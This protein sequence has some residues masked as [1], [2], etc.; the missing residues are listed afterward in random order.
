[1]IAVNGDRKIEKPA[2]NH[3]LSRDTGSKDG[4]LPIVAKDSRWGKV[5]MPT[6]PDTGY[7]VPRI[8]VS[9]VDEFAGVVVVPASV[10][11]QSTR[12]LACTKSE[13]P[14]KMNR[15]KSRLRVL[16]ADDS[17]AVLERVSGLLREEFDVVGTVSDGLQVP[18]AIEKTKPDLLVIDIGLPGMNGIQTVQRLTKMG[19]TAKIV[20]LTVSQDEDYISAAIA[21]GAAGYVTKAR[22][23][24]DLILALREALA[25]KFFVWRPSR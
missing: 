5:D 22:M 1:V 20:F 8:L 3:A 13:H 15:E 12:G 21:A 14:V 19:T 2:Q 17:D 6:R 16:L 4:L 23:Q 7:P 25:G 11:L 24:S 18:A 10:A 9:E